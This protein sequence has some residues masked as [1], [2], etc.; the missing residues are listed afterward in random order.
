[1]NL[2]DKPIETNANQEMQ[3]KRK[4]GRPS[5]ADILARQKATVRTPITGERSILH[6]EGKMPGFKYRWIKDTDETG[7]EVLRFLSA[8]YEF[9]RRSEGI[10]VGD[11]SVYASKAVGSL[12]RVSAGSQGDYLYLMKI[13]ED[14]YKEDQEAKSRIVDQTEDAIKAPEIGGSYGSIKIS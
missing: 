12:V 5:R 14:W 1:M 4:A 8:G 9:A 11:N 3:P 2:F 6:V 7:S 10:I 13:P